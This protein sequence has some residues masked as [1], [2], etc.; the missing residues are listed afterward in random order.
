LRGRLQ[1]LG[2]KPPEELMLA[3]LDEYQ[4]HVEK[5]RPKQN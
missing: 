5:L 3:I 2:S 1:F 4:E